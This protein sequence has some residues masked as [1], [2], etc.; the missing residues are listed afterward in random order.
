MVPCISLRQFPLR[1]VPTSSFPPALKAPP[2]FVSAGALG[3]WVFHS[4]CYRALQNPFRPQR[5]GYT[6]AL[7]L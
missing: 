5:C 6:G 4:L 3:A 1:T 7:Y 2:G